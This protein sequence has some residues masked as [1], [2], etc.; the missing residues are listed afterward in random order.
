MAQFGCGSGRSE[1]LGLHRGGLQLLRKS[2]QKG[3]G[4]DKQGG[5]GVFT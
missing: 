2:G 4:Q 1:A 5:A 3:A